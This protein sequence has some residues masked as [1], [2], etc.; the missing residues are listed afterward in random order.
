MRD[1]SIA[2][3]PPKRKVFL[4]EKRL[5]HSKFMPHQQPPQRLLLN[6]TVIFINIISL[7]VIRMRSRK[8]ARLKAARRPLRCYHASQL[9]GEGWVQE[10]MNG[11]PDRIKTELGMRCHVFKNLAAVLATC[12]LKASKHL[13][14]EEQLA[15]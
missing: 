3:L 14:C 8:R 7:A 6:A 5:S 4:H 10:L 15:I 2:T 13:S 12:G 9:S 11:H 1:R